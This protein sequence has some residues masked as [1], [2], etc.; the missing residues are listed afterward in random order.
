MA[1]NN[2][3]FRIDVSDIEAFELSADVIKGPRISFK[4]LCDLFDVRDFVKAEKSTNES[5]HWL[6]NNPQGLFNHATL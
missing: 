2:L 4:G 3:V 6:W 5:D 1:Y